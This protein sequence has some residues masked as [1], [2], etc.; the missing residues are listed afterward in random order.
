MKVNWKKRAIS[1]VFPTIENDKKRLFGNY[2]PEGQGFESLIACQKSRKPIRAC[3]IFAR[4]GFESCLHTP[5]ACAWAGAHT[6]EYRYVSHGTSV[7][8]CALLP[9][10]TCK[11][12][13]YRVPKKLTGFWLMAFYLLYWKP[14][15]IAWC[16]ASDSLWDTCNNTVF[17]QNFLN[18]VKILVL[19]RDLN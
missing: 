1:R 8:L 5:G 6:G 13:P 19:I 17:F 3:G 4:K 11:R 12:I 2:G 10:E 14:F 7:I 9:C 15:R 18:S 16:N